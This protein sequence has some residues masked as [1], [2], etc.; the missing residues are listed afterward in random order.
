MKIYTR[1]GDDGTTGV[2]GPGRLLKSDPRIEAYGTVDELNAALGL[3]R[4]ADPPGSLAI[5]LAALQRRLFQVGAELATTDERMLDT[6]DRVTDSDIAEIEAVIDRLEAALPP[7]HQFVLP[8]GTSAAAHLHLARTICRRAAR[9]R[10][11]RVP[12]A[13]CASSIAWPT[14]CS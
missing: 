11:R 14:C 7:L 5:D 2:L 9:T 4:A 1:G 12:S 10:P 8:G 13:S 6:L 3:A